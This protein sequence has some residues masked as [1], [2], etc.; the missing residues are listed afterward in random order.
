MEGLLKTM[1]G[2]EKTN[3][4][5]QLLDKVKNL[6]HGEKEFAEL[7]ILLDGNDEKLK[8]LTVDYCN[9]R[10]RIW[11]ARKL[12]TNSVEL[13]K[14]LAIVCDCYGKLLKNK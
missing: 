5:M 3:A 1:E 11:N 13:K 14:L 7:E 4:G 10:Q 8:M 12:Q 9:K 2:I 6:L